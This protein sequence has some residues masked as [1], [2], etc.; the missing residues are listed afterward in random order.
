MTT[1]QPSSSQGKSILIVE[2][3]SFLLQLLSRKLS[4]EDFDV[5]KAEDGEKALEIAEEEEF[6]LILLDLI[7]PEM[8]G[9]EV[10]EKLKDKPKTAD[11]PVVILSNL[12]EEDEIDKGM[13]LGAYDYMVKAHHTPGEI[14]E[15]AI[16]VLE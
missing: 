1:Q 14:V 2:D 4:D 10:L 16:S 15:K 6:E 3:D 11:I 9:F 5:S 8:G 13:K 7:L 12:E